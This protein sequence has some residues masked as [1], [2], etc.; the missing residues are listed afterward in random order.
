MWE[1]TLNSTNWFVTTDLFVWPV[2]NSFRADADR[3][4]R[5]LKNVIMLL[6]KQISAVSS[7]TTW[8]YNVC[9]AIVRMGL[10]VTDKLLRY[11][12]MAWGTL[13]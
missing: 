10:D 6:S 5:V 13:A 3:F 2:F 7:Q 9:G 8:P 11:F 4:V 12:A 1:I